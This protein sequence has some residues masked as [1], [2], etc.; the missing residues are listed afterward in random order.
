MEQ[1]SCITGRSSNRGGFGSEKKKRASR[2]CLSIF[3]GDRL[4]SQHCL[5]CPHIQT[6]FG[7]SSL[8]FSFTPDPVEL[9]CWRG[10]RMLQY[11][12]WHVSSSTTQCYVGPYIFVFVFQK[13]Q[14]EVMIS[15]QTSFFDFMTFSIKL[16]EKWLGKDMGHNFID[17][18]T[19]ACD[20][21]TC[22]HLS[23]ES[24]PMCVFVFVDAGELESS[25]QSSPLQ[26]PSYPPIRCCLCFSRSTLRV[27]SFNTSYFSAQ[28]LFPVSW[29][30]SP[31]HPVS[32]IHPQ[33]HNLHQHHQ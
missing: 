7:A 1:S 20:C 18:S 17:N 22:C 19:A 26:I 3:R 31:L 14:S 25:P 8:P 29:P 33:Q 9:S 6:S 24:L 27:S 5:L 23:S 16:K 28:N 12:L 4:P 21:L 15:L 30:S 11:A 13:T 2:Q 10:I 32:L